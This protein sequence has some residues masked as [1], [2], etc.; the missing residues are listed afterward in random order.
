MPLRL[1]HAAERQPRSHAPSAG[2]KGARR[3]SEG[4]PR[5]VTAQLHQCDQDLGITAELLTGPPPEVLRAAAEEAELLVIGT[6]GAGGL[7]GFLLGS[8]AMNT[9]AHA[10]RPVVLVRAPRAAQDEQPGQEP[11]AMSTRSRS[12]T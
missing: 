9:V 7:A 4:V 2:P 11:V 10:E 8:V 12:R 5:E 1:V 3:W 6:I